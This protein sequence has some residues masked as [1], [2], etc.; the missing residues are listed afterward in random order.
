MEV[1]DEVNGPV[2]LQASGTEC[3]YFRSNILRHLIQADIGE[4][5]HIP[6]AMHQDRGVSPGA[7]QR[8]IQLGSSVVKAPAAKKSFPSN[9]RAPFEASDLRK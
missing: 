7:C 1:A 9:T 4:F 6:I 3:M 5:H 2:L 8:P